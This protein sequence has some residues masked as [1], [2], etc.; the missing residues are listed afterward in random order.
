M[1]MWEQMYE[2]LAPRP[3]T[4]LRRLR[5]GCIHCIK[6]L[7]CALRVFIK[8]KIVKLGTLSASERETKASEISEKSVQARPCACQVARPVFTRARISKHS[9]N[10][11]GSWFDQFG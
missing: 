8:K 3:V 11:V 4:Q 6:V 9:V 10:F 1:K 7:S 2:S 5:G